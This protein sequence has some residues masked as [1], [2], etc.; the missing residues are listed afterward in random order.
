MKIYTG[1]SF[2]K[3]LEKVIELEMGI[4]ICTSTGFPASKDF[5]NTFCAMDNGAFGCYQ[6]G[7]PFQADLFRDNIKHCHKLGIPL[8]FI[9]CPD[10]VAGGKRSLDFSYSWARDELQTAPNLAL[11]IQDGFAERYVKPYMLEYFTYLFIGGTVEWKWENAE[12][13][14]EFGHKEGKRVHI[15]QC[16]QLKYL[17][18]AYNMGADSVDSTSM[19]RNKSWHIIDEYRAKTQ[20][21]QTNL[22]N[23][24]KK[25]K[26]PSLLKTI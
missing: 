17:L 5:K 13:W 18:R 2:G 20:D 3:D 24:E 14:V 16:G 4:M 1:N 15:G 22:F 7:Y 11:V 12:R 6:K 8:D 19:V 26:D 21:N 23:Y 9:A 10:V 25:K